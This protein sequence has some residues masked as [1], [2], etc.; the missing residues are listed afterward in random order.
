MDAAAA[1]LTIHC[2]EHLVQHTMDSGKSAGKGSEEG[3]RPKAYPSETVL[4]NKVTE[5]RTVHAVC[6]IRDSQ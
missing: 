3:E 6:L 4:P 5:N 1:F 2:Q